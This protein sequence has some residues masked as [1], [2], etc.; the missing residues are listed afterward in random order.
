VI[1]PVVGCQRVFDAVQSKLPLLD[2]IRV[3]AHRGADEARARKLGLVPCIEG[4]LRRRVIGSRCRNGATHLPKTESA[5]KR[6]QAGGGP[7][8][9]Y[10]RC[11][12]LMARRIQERRRRP[13]RSCRV[14]VD[15]SCRQALPHSLDCV[16]AP[17]ARSE[18]RRA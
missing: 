17:R 4:S 10:G 7:G 18:W 14:P 15:M 11:C 8:L 12:H 6:E 9:L 1:R 13:R 5:S 2:S 16:C 3:P